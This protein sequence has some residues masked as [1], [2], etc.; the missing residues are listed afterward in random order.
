[1]IGFSPRAIA[2][3]VAT[4]PLP[5]AAQARSTA[6]SATAVDAVF[7][8]W[9][10]TST[11]GCA[12]GVARDGRVILTRA[13]G[14][15]NLE[16]DVP[17]TPTTIFEAGSV[18]KQFTAAAIVLL[19]LDGRLSLEDPVRKHIPELPP[20]GDSITIRH[21][22]NHTSGLRDWGTVVGA[23]GWPRGT[24][25]YTQTHVL[26]VV[27]RQKSLNYRPGDEYLYSN[28]NY[29]LAAMIVERVSGQSLP[30][31]TKAR[32]FQPLGMTNTSWR[33][34]YRRIVKNRSTAYSGNSNTGFRQ[35]MPFENVYG[36]SSLLTTV[37][38]L[39]K[40]NQNFVNPVVGGPR[41]VAEMQTQGRLNSGRTITYALGLERDSWRGVPVVS[42]GGAT[43]G[44]RAFLAR[45]P[46]Q[47]LDVALLCNSGSVNPA[48]ISNQVAEVFLRDKLGPATTQAASGVRLPAAVLQARTGLFRHARTGTPLR[49]TLQDSTL[50]IGGQR[51]TPIAENTFVSGPLRAVFSSD[52]ASFRVIEP[53]GDTTLYNRVADWNPTA[54]DLQE[55]AGRYTSDEAEVTY[56]IAMQNGRLVRLD[57]Y[58][59][60][61]PLTPSYKDAFWQ[62]GVLVTFRR[63]GA[64]RV[65]GMS[66]NLGRVRDLRF[67]RR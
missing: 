43:A 15:A 28:T 61:A 55:F 63:D 10:S 40:W 38:D 29:N 33:D 2:L 22:L 47:R 20:Y 5:L 52:A 25:T 4:I 62:G 39:I 3:L 57:R 21:M 31:F 7:A 16:Y 60:S 42:H 45:Y 19:A 65:V 1:M 13:Y 26:D 50:R 67:D 17:I 27:A 36:N 48:A 37:E 8:G 46:E 24:R 35:D 18:S 56:T 32:L 34:E 59:E 53:D 44:Y 49:L 54:A 11:P 12:V 14:M 9:T 41:F 58:G 6:D 64:G 66:L 30:D 51:L 23:A